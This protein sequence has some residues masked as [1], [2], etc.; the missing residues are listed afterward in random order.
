VVEL[1]NKERR[2]EAGR[3]D[4]FMGLSDADKIAVRKAQELAKKSGLRNKGCRA[5][6]IK[7]GGSRR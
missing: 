7:T 1:S 6:L 5:W 3:R 4:L 2:G